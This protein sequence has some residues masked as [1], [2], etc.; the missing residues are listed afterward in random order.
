MNRT[1]LIPTDFS[2]ESLNL[3][4]AAAQSAITE[5]VNIVFFHAVYSPN[6]MVDL[7]F[8]SQQ[9]RNELL[10]TENFRNGCT[11]I[12]NK[13]ASSISSNRIEFFSGNTQT[14]FQN[15]LEGN[16]ITEIFIPKNYTLRKTS[17]LSFNPIPFINEC[18]LPKHEVAWHRDS[19][20]PEKNLL[21][22][23]FSDTPAVSI[24]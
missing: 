6:S 12:L 18:N 8:R 1:I 15:F 20:T 17:A 9:K 19:T 14:A 3:F 11:I 24:Q 4:K 22:E 13:F 10:I 2:I 23:L 21:A 5:R 7:L 16:R